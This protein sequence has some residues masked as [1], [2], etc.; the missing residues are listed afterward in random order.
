MTVAVLETILG[1]ASSATD[2]VVVGGSTLDV[3]AD[4]RRARIRQ[5]LWEGPLGFAV[6]TTMVSL[7]VVGVVWWAGKAARPVIKDG[8]EAVRS[9][10]KDGVEAARPVVKEGIVAAQ[11]LAERVGREGLMAAA[12]THS[13]GL[14]AV[15]M[16]TAAGGLSRLFRRPV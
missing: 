11:P 4:V 12:E 15:A 10:V 3:T 7:A 5:P 8:V 6:K 14:F 16:A 13:Q 1:T 9:V 2:V